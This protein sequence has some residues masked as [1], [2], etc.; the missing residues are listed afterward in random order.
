M[1]AFKQDFTIEQSDDCTTLTF[2][3]ISNV[4]DNDENYTYSSFSTKN[5]GVYD[6]TNTLIGSLIPIV[7]ETP[8]TFALDKD[9]F[10]FIRE[11]FIHGTDTPLIKE[12]DVALSCYVDLS[13]G[14][15][16]IANILDENALRDNDDPTL[17]NIIKA[18]EAAK[19]FGARGNATLSQDMLDLANSYTDI[20]NK[21]LN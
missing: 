8:V 13:F 18:V 11:T 14:S 4:G 20:T 17:F 1:A 15:S 16:I 6:S 19:I 10:L 2:T 3:D 5:I 7:D 12:Y 21:S 9:R